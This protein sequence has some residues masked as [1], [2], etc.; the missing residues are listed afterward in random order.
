MAKPN[1]NE[2]S[3]SN[4]ES[5]QQ[6]VKAIEND[7]IETYKNEDSVHSENVAQP[8]SDS[9]ALESPNAAVKSV[10]VTIKND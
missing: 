3:K 7:H 4:T 10:E 1:Y 6:T 5:V 9:E 2:M 8:S